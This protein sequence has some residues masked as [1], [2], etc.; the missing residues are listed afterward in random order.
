LPRVPPR[1]PRYRPFR[2]ALWLLYFAVI[3]VAFGVVVRSVVMNLRGPHRP[4]ATGV[5]PTRA[6]LRV[7]VTEL[8]ALHAEQNERAWT[9]GGHIGE[10]GA[11]EH[12][13]VWAREWEQRVDD[14]SDRCRL[15]A[16]DPDPQGF[17]G[18]RE[19]ARARDAVLELHRAYRAQVNRFA[20]ED[21]DLA[22][23]AAAALGEAREALGR[24]PERG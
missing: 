14:L 1:D 15:D 18:R 16:T 13:D 17:G 10:K 12:W 20:Q 19:L 5:L 21:A 8:E 9:L 4:P 6:A 24:P 2:L 22:R 23:R 3:A 11:I 7:C